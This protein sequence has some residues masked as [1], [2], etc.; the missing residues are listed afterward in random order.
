MK[1]IQLFKDGKEL[2]ASDGIMKVDG[3][4]NNASIHYE[5]IK[6]NNRFSANFPH[7]I[8]NQFAIYSNRIGSKLSNIYNV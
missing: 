6:R 8:A 5:V 3:R 7:K 4:L 2:M 1:T